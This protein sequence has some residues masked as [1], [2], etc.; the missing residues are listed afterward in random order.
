MARCC[1]FSEFWS[2]RTPNEP[3]LIMDALS[4]HSG[5]SWTSGG[6]DFD[7]V[8]DIKVHGLGDGIGSLQS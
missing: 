1:G 5:G 4:A 2:L 3:G 8:R 7:M 6:I